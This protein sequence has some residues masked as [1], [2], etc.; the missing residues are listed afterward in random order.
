MGCAFATAAPASHTTHYRINALVKHSRQPLRSH[1]GLPGGQ[2]L[3][4]D[5][6]TRVSFGD[7]SRVRDLD[8]GVVGTKICACATP[9]G[10]VAPPASG[11]SE[12]R[13]VGARKVSDLLGDL[14]R[15]AEKYWQVP[16]RRGVVRVVIAHGDG[17]PSCQSVNAL[18]PGRVPTLVEIT[19]VPTL[20]GPMKPITSRYY[21]SW[22]SSG[23]FLI[24]CRDG[25]AWRGQ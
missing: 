2:S 24:V 3:R 12:P 17:R 6:V 1:D 21:M 13:G 9:R 22:F 11:R 14:S 10:A 16:L 8:A 25:K 20:T 23:C 18:V 19:E 15:Q 4:V 7:T 5:E